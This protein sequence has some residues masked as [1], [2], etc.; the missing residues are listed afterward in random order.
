MVGLWSNGMMLFGAGGRMTNDYLAKIDEVYDS[1][2]TGRT[3]GALVRLVTVI[4]EGED[5]ALAD[6]RLQDFM[7]HLLPHLPRY[8][9]Q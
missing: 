6:E 1:L 8:I 9:P 2:T 7:G 4:A 3:G 5:I